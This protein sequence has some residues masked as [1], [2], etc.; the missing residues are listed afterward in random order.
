MRRRLVLFTLVIALIG[1]MSLPVCATVGVTSEATAGTTIYVAGNP[2]L[3][4]VE[5][6][7]EETESYLGLLPTFYAMVSEKSGIDFTYIHAGPR[8][9]QERL[10][11]NLQ[12]ELISA[13]IR[14]DVEVSE[15][16]TLFEYTREGGR[17]TAAL[18]FTD[19][20][21]ETVREVIRS[22]LA[23][24]S[25]SQWLSAALE[26]AE[27]PRTV[28]PVTLYIVAGVMMAIAILF[29]VL[30]LKVR[31][32]KS[33]QMMRRI[34]PLTGIGNLEHLNYCFEHYITSEVYSLYYVVYI[35]LDAAEVE[36][37]AGTTQVEE[38]QRFAAEILSSDI[39]ETDFVARIGEGVFGLCCQAPDAERAVQYVREQLT[40]LNAN[41]NHDVVGY[42]R[43][44]F[45]AGVYHMGKQQLSLETALNNAKQGYIYAVDNKMDCCLCDKNIL[46]KHLLQ[47]DLQK[48]LA[49]AIENNEF[50]LYLQF[51]VRAEDGRIIGAEALS[52]WHSVENGVLSPAY[53]IEDMKRAGIISKL[54]FSMLEKAC[55]QLETWQEDGYGWLHLSCNFT[56]IT[57]S[58][59]DFLQK[60]ND[61][62]N[63]YSFDRKNLVIEL[64]EDSLVDNMAVAYQ[65]ILACKE[66]GFTVALD[67]LG[68]GYSSFSDLCD[69]PVDII[70]VDRHIVAKA[71]TERGNALLRGI[72]TMAHGLGIE[73]LCEGVESE[74]ESKRIKETGCDYIQGF[75]YSRVLP[76]ENAMEYYKKYN[77]QRI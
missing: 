46:N 49:A 8:N 48:R 43:L 77:S 44:L 27:K 1:I 59:V 70:K 30:F 10:A 76:Q 41:R 21:P 67:D 62:V 17:Y 54:D 50:V 7:D 38:M 13:H 56:R 31:P 40:K 28:V 69:Y 20:M 26:L 11:K 16:C 53:Y 73:V 3:F 58:E 4:P 72:T 15:V 47:H 68:A 6:Y 74:T 23:A 29:L 5:Y 2:D 65:N 19:I 22:E 61:T 39:A 9:Q 34:D 75:Y 60:F 33:E 25:D 14:G 51:I 32:K 35:A 55:R 52:R 36:K 66:A 24:T 63:Q 45:Y 71:A 12:A 57:I 37:Y 42:R 18:G 64:T